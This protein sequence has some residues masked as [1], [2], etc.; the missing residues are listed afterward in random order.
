MRQACLLGAPKPEADAVPG[1]LLALLLGCGLL[2]LLAAALHVFA[3]TSH[4]VAAGETDN[5]QHTHYSEQFFHDIFPI[6]N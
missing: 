4:G 3:H 1:G 5:H 6:E 2:N